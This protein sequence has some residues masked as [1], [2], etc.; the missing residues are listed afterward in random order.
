MQSECCSPLLRVMLILGVIRPADLVTI[1]K[2]EMARKEKDTLQKLQFPPPGWLFDR[3]HN[4]RCSD[5]SFMEEELKNKKEWIC[6]MFNRF[7]TT[8]SNII[9]SL[10]CILFCSTE[11]TC[12]NSLVNV[13]ILG[14]PWN[15]QNNNL[16]TTTIYYTKS[17]FHIN[18]KP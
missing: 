10:N 5:K 1:T 18:P 2:E 9:L 12:R 15:S 13:Q 3:L 6:P 8:T 17:S 11:Y 16:S 4:A 7:L 14:M